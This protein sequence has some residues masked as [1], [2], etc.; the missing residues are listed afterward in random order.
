LIIHGVDFMD[1]RQIGKMF[2]SPIEASKGIIQK[3]IWIDDSNVEIVFMN[4][5]IAQAVIE[6]L[7]SDVKKD[8]VKM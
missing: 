6:K 2:S 4:P 5:Q 3:I 1:T 8:K 7:T